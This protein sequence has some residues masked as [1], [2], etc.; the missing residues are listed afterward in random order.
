M[1]ISEFSKVLNSSLCSSSGS[2][3]IVRLTTEGCKATPVCMSVSS[4]SSGKEGKRK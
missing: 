4:G 2:V 3:D 1:D